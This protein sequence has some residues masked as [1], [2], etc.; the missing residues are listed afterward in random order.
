[1]KSIILAL[2]LIFMVGCV[3]TIPANEQ[4]HYVKPLVIEVHIVSDS[5]LYDV[6]SNKNTNVLGYTNGYKIFILGK[7]L[8]GETNVLI[9]D[10]VLGHELRHILRRRGV[11]V[12]DPDEEKIHLY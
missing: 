6:E 2:S 9:D 8:Q 5:S 11:P 4:F 10:E 1:M 3:S 7:K 12:Y